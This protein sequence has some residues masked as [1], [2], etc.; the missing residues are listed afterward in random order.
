MS[1][2]APVVTGT[3][4][5]TSTQ[6]HS[7]QTTLN[8]HP[9]SFLPT[10]D[11]PA[12]VSSDDTTNE[13]PAVI[14]AQAQAQQLFRQR[15]LLA[16][17]QQ[18]QLR[19]QQQYLL[20]Q[21]PSYIS[22]NSQPL[23]PQQTAQPTLNTKTM[24]TRPTN[25]NTTDLTMER[26]PVLSPST[27]PL[28]TIPVT[29]SASAM[30]N[31]THSK[32]KPVTGLAVLRLLQ[33]AEQLSPGDQAHQRGYWDGFVTDFF[34]PSSQ[35]KLGLRN[36][37]TDE[38]KAYYISHYSTATFF[39]T[40]YDCGVTSIQLTLEQTM[41]YVL[42]GG[43]MN[44]ECPRANF[45]Y[46]YSTGSLVTSTGHLWVRFSLTANGIWKIKHFEFACQGNEEYIS[47]SHLLQGKDSVKLK[48]STKCTLPETSI[49]A[50]GFPL[51]TYHLIQMLDVASRLDDV[52]F[53]SLIS[54]STAKDSLNSMALNIEQRKDNKDNLQTDTR[55][56]HN[57]PE[58]TP[59]PMMENNDVM[60][61]SPTITKK[62]PSR[63]T[64][65]ARRKSL[66]SERAL[67]AEKQETDGNQSQQAGANNNG[68]KGS[69]STVV[70]MEGNPS[71]SS[72]YMANP[73]QQQQQLFM[74]QQRKTLIQQHHLQQQQQALLQRQHQLHETGAS[75]DN[76]PSPLPSGLSLS[77]QQQQT[78]DPLTPTIPYHAS[79]SQYP[80]SFG[81]TQSQQ[82]QL[83]GLEEFTKSPQQSCRL[84]KGI[85]QNNES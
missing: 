19:H 72:Q 47:R 46:H 52:A 9:S 37:D 6:Q 29:R 8:T 21:Q 1:A 69:D 57:I 16:Y 20:H 14:Q 27:L 55:P 4:Q 58:P 63:S 51:R 38:Q 32:K 33:F 43:Q 62:K 76:G 56:P 81:L 15:Q 67:M 35:T 31:K 49:N 59:S 36:S 79:F 41:E 54:G 44:V 22:T 11:I 53:Y 5:H 82:Q 61:S 23:T 34:T 71:V 13:S 28:T 73:F 74:Q 64:I 24:P 26:T 75:M 39:H 45:I 50:W 25:I 30:H 2:I 68:G 60:T 12:L 66:K 83:D 77:Q 84:H 80:D 65:M 48:K 42:P 78:S 10:P 70:K 3:L 85:M 18:E 40:L 7:S 17:Q